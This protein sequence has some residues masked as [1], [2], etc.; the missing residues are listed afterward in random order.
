MSKGSVRS[1]KK[2]CDGRAAGRAVRI[3]EPVG[4]FGLPAIVAN[5]RGVR[6]GHSSA[7]IRIPSPIVELLPQFALQQLSG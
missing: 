3:G 1:S 2:G 4:L 6:S 5:V 7:A